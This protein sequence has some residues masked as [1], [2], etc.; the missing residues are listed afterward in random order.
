MANVSHKLIKIVSFSTEQSQCH[1][2]LQRQAL[3]M[4]TLFCETA[5]SLVAY[6]SSRKRQ[7]GV[8]GF[9]QLLHASIRHRFTVAT[10]QR[11]ASRQCRISKRNGEAKRGFLRCWQRGRIWW[12]LA[13]ARSVQVRKCG[14]PKIDC[15]PVDPCRSPQSNSTPRS[16]STRYLSQTRPECIF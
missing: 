9:G 14:S 10:I 12:P 3:R 11:H 2:P 13:F 16:L 6:F 1:D 15:Q 8:R 5:R 7:R 4:I